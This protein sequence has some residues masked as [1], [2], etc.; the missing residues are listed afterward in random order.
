MTSPNTTSVTDLPNPS[1]QVTSSSI[2]DGRIQK[3]H[4]RQTHGGENRSPGL[5][6]HRLPESARFLSI[7]ADDPDA[8]KPAGKVWVHWNLFNIPVRGELIDILPGGKIEG[9]AGTTS[10]GDRGWEGMAPPDGVHTYR[11]A[12]FASR[13]PIQVDLNRPWT[14]EEFERAYGQQTLRKAMITGQFG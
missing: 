4:A 7:V 11:F 9:D 3:V 1:I 8:M 2:A 14:I 6:V 10:S 12:V 5:T 13:E